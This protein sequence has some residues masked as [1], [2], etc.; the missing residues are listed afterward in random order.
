[1]GRWAVSSREQIRCY[2]QAY[3]PNLHN[4]PAIRSDLCHYADFALLRAYALTDL[5]I[6]LTAHLPT[7]PAARR[8]LN[9]FLHHPPRLAR[10]GLVHGG[11]RLPQRRLDRLARFEQ[12]GP[13]P[14]T[15]VLIACLLAGSYFGR[16]SFEL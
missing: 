12:I 9:R 2:Y 10:R 14:L 6:R 3:G 4:H 13:R 8:F 15:R 1:M 11:P 16:R 7:S 5:E